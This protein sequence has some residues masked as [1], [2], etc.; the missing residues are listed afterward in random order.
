MLSLL[1]Y[2]GLQATAFTS[3]A[4]RYRNAG[5]VL[6]YHNVVSAADTTHAGNPALHMPLHRFESQMRWLADHY[7]I[8]PLSEFLDRLV[9]GKPMRQQATLTFDDG[10][11]GVFEHAW[12]VL[13]DLGLSATV[14]IITG[15][16]ARR[17]PFWWDDPAT[18]Q[19]SSTRRDE[20]LTTLRGDGDVILRSLGA[21][22]GTEDGTAA[23]C[24][25]ARW[26]VVRE[27]ARSGMELGV[28]STTHRALPTL[29]DDEL[30]AEIE[31]SRETLSRETGIQPAFFSFPY[32][33][34]DERTR[35]RVQHAGYRAAVT[36]DYGLVN[37]GVDL[38][39]LP[40]VNVP[41]AIAGP[42]FK[43]WAAGLNLRE[44]FR[45]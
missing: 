13:R 16:P 8:L 33:L 45:A 31:G 22:P 2:R 6:C 19:E 30:V 21:D 14:F 43:A 28:H 25:P 7:D 34:W 42:A 17:R 23:A 11:A 24:L 26:Q 15:A 44:T 39:S 38:W 1:A 37:P 35:Q 5:V 10:Y 41:S 9:D 20:W 36:L 27:A 32:G 18:Q 4:R 12:P 40:R 29:S 3:I